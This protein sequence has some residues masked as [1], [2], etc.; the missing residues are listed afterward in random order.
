[1]IL[2]QASS[3]LENHFLSQQSDNIRTLSGHAND[4]KKLLES[5]DRSLAL[6]MFDEYLQK[7]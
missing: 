1:M 4:L 5:N 3:F 2:V 6:F 7:Q